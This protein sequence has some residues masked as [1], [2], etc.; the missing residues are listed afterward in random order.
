LAECR[1]WAAALQDPGGQAQRAC[2]AE[3]LRLRV[4]ARAAYEALLALLR[5]GA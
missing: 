5:E 3:V 2:A 4:E 1:L